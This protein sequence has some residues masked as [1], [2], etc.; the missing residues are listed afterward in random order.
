[1][2]IFM[3]LG[4]LP[5]AILAIWFS[6][7]NAIEVMRANAVDRLHMHTT[8]LAERVDKWHYGNLLA[9]RT[10]S[11]NPDITS[12][13]SAR[14]F[15]A[16]VT[17]LN[18]HRPA[19]YVAATFD[20]HGGVVTDAA[21]RPL[22]KA[23]YKDR[24]WFQEAM[25]GKDGAYELLISRSTGFPAFAYSAPIPDLPKGD[26]GDEGPVIALVQSI[27]K[28]KKLYSGETHGLY[29]KETAEAVRQFQQKHYTGLT[30]N[31]IADAATVQAIVNTGGL[32]WSHTYR[33]TL[34]EIKPKGAL[35]VATFL[36]QIAGFIDA[37]RIGETGFS[38][39]V[40]QKGR[41]LAHP[42]LARISEGKVV[43]Y[44]SHEPVRSFLDG[45]SGLLHF[46][47]AHGTEWE[48]YVK[49]LDN[50]W[51]AI[52]QQQS[53]ELMK[54]ERDFLQ[55]ALLTTLVVILTMTILIWVISGRLIMPVHQLSLEA[56]RLTRY[57]SSKSKGEGTDAAKADADLL[58]LLAKGEFPEST[59]CRAS[60]SA[61]KNEIGQLT[62]SFAAM[63]IQLK[64]L[65]ENFEQQ[66]A[67]R[68]AELESSNQALVEARELAESA[69]QAK[70][71][72][73]ANMSHEI[74]TPMNAVLGFTEILK[75]READPE[76]ARYI[77]NIYKSSKTL[78]NLI[79]DILD[80]SKI[81]AGKLDLQYTST[82]LQSLLTD[83]Q[84]L[85][86]Q[87]VA[88]KGVQFVVELAS[89]IPKALILDETRI[90]QVL[91]N[92]I[93]N[94]IKFTESGTIRLIAAGLEAPGT[95][96]SRFD[97]VLKVQDTGIGIPTEQ[98][99][100]I[101]GAF[102]QMKGQKTAEFGGTGLGLAI[103][104]RLVELMEGTISVKSTVGEGTTFTV[105]LPGVEVAATDS[106]TRQSGSSSSVENL[107]FEPAT[108]LITDDIDLNRQMLMTYLG[109]WQFTL[110]E[111]E[112]GLECLEK[113]AEHRPDLIL[114]DM[115]MPV[116]DGYEAAEALKVDDQLS[117]IPVIAVTASAL[118]QDEERIAALCDGYLRKPV[119]KSD[120]VHEIIRFLPHSTVSPTESDAAQG[121]VQL[122]GYTQAERH[123]PLADLPT[124]WRTRA[125]EMA[126]MSLY[127]DL[128]AHVETIQADFPAVAESIQK[129]LAD[130]RFDL[131][132]DFLKKT[133]HPRS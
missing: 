17:F 69:N 68:T 45:K 44:S 78:L 51:A 62:K 36:T 63:T 130:F 57:Y 125:K 88:E 95:T 79:N 4:V 122:A 83:V 2:T 75:G 109:D 41:L 30:A 65:L 35:V 105:N 47:D 54:Q 126:E 107:I 120:V 67:E 99:S 91:I 6:T 128:A 8:S 38:Y 116:M 94:A 102:E 121:D 64:L 43:D 11:W 16:L 13:D 59:L 60:V 9:V 19:Y 104:N 27:L 22:S 123:Q 76:K 81:E 87:K 82:S 110:I 108:I 90:R 21:G 129:H 52:I 127:K 111:A 112:S 132:L 92:L 103:T 53:N 113:A 34:R 58:E 72:F 101:F 24:Y 55:Y 96:Q 40:D 20:E 117:L 15:P 3:V 97:L 118:K 1:M 85:F 119:S 100:R 33:D 48:S 42:E 25:T 12:M 89:D 124:E 28:E 37:V 131:V 73:L 86:G 74:R 50:G 5:A 115:K 56:M 84:I 77:A 14:Q 31:G 98:Q 114:L 7:T 46:E 10:L 80:L 49:Q 66:V 18:T 106:I 29:T 61:G 39:L 32:S 133:D 26:L 70:S 23:N 93:G 71:D